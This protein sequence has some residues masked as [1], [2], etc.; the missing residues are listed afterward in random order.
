MTDTPLTSSALIITAHLGLIRIGACSGY[1][2]NLEGELS[3]SAGLQV[4]Q[5]L[6]FPFLTPYP[7]VLLPAGPWALVSEAI[8]SCHARLHEQGVPRI[9]TDIRIGTK[10]PH[11]AGKPDWAAHLGENERKLESVNR[12]LAGAH[13]SDSGS[14]SGAASGTGT[15]A[16]GASTGAGRQDVG[17][18]IASAVATGSEDAEAEPTGG[19]AGRG[20]RTAEITQEVFKEGAIPARPSIAESN[21]GQGQCGRSMLVLELSVFSSRVAC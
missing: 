16:S 19:Y 4:R 1:G 21:K 15:V 18:G 11:L 6:T 13:L 20:L 3:S 8:A 9:A 5:H 10:A 17:T 7:L 12:R 2:T 14:A